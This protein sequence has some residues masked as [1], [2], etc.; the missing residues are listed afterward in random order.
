MSLFDFKMVPI[1]GILYGLAWVAWLICVIGGLGNTRLLALLSAAQTPGFAPS[2][3]Y[4][5]AQELAEMN[6]MDSDPVNGHSP[7]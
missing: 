4:R 3:R 1:W 2:D 5:R 7:K 6:E